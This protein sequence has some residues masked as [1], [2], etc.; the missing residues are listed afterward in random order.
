M[1]KYE[2]LG[3]EDAIDNFLSIK[4]KENAR[5]IRKAVRRKKRKDLTLGERISAFF[6]LHFHKSSAIDIAELISS[7]KTFN[8]PMELYT[9]P[10]ELK[11]ELEYV[12]SYTTDSVFYEL[13]A[14][15][16]SALMRSQDELRVS[17]AHKNNELLKSLKKAKLE[18]KYVT[19]WEDGKPVNASLLSSI[20][21]L[22]NK[23]LYAL[24]FSEQSSA[25]TFNTKNA[26]EIDVPLSEVETYLTDIEDMLRK[27]E[28]QESDI[29]KNIQQIRIIFRKRAV[30]EELNNKIW[31]IVC[32]LRTE[33]KKT[34]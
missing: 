10:P 19:Y 30:L 34:V 5:N 16:N 14:A 7:Y 2:K 26:N 13:S 18:S 31:K 22:G 6:D 11:Q 23:K 9:L 33:K 25:V 21:H 32:S 4:Q 12:G 8:T 27:G 20:V 1:V 29:T 3:L 17:L 15:I 28:I 24:H